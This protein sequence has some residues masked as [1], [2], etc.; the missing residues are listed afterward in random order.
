[1]VKICKGESSVNG[2]FQAELTAQPNVVDAA[3]KTCNP[4]HTAGMAIDS[5]GN[6]LDMQAYGNYGYGHVAARYNL[7]GNTVRGKFFV[8]FGSLDFD[9]L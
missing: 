6:E 3:M 1:M 5:W 9:I 7:T 8:Y 2:V 4:L